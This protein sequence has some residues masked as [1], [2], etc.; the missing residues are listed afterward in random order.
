MPMGPTLLGAS[1]WYEASASLRDLAAFSVTVTLGSGDCEAG[2]INTHQWTYSVAPSGAVKLVGDSGDA[3]EYQVPTGGP[4]PA[5]VTI[6]LVAGPVCPVERNPPNPGC[7]RRPVAN[8]QVVVH[9][10]DGAVVAQGTSGNDGTVSFD[11]PAGAYYA[12]ASPVQGLMRSPDAQAFSVVGGTSVGLR[13]E[14]DTGIG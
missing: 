7:A 5:H 13:F 9:S 6:A 8:A 2:C 14:Y 4:E 11:L 10:P 3:V 12:E 1:A